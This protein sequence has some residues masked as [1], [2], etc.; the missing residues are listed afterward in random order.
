MYSRIIVPLDGS[1]LAERALPYV[2][3]F[4]EKLTV[5]IQLLQA[6]SPTPSEL[7]DSDHGRYL[8]QMD[9]AL[10][11]RAYDYLNQVK[12][13][14]PDAKAEI[15]C[16]VQPGDPASCIVAESEADPE[17]LVVMSTHGRSGIGRWVLGSVTDKVLHA[18]RNPLWIIRSQHD[19]SSDEVGLKTI[20]VA[21]DGSPIAEQILPHV[22]FLSKSL[23]FN[24]KLVRAR[25]S[26]QEYQHYMESHLLG[27]GA[28]VYTGPYEVFSKEADAKAMDYLHDV[29][30]KLQRQGIWSIEEDLIKEHA[31][32]AIIE[33]VGHDSDKMVA[34][35][36]HG[37]SGIPRWLLGSVTDRVVRHAGVP[38]LVVRANGSKVK[39]R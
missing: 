29:R 38:V 19:I 9:A 26:M 15:S 16:L 14:I 5:P 10:Q 18:T 36:T 8:D 32:E 22:V 39:N 3:M 27:G 25:P 1:P 33:S 4:A 12:S 13:S 20:V 7:S 11:D 21:L 28:T 6:Y 24:I 17:A 34:M 23:G 35:T 31:P 37:R 2:R 30:M